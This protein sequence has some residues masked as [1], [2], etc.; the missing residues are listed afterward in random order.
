MAGLV[1]CWGLSLLVLCLLICR[2]S[3]LTKEEL[4]P[5]GQ[6]GGEE[7]D[8]FITNGG[9]SDPFP[10]TVPIV[11]HGKKYSSVIV[12]GKGI[13]TFT[14][15]DLGTPE[16][17]PFPL[18][19]PAIAPFFADIETENDGVVTFRESTKQELLDK[20]NAHVHQA[21]PNQASFLARSVLIATWDDVVGHGNPNYY[22]NTFQVVVANSG[23]DSFA[24]FLYP[25]GAL[26]WAKTVSRTEGKPE[27]FALAG[28][29]GEDGKVQTLEGSGTDY[30][31]NLPT[32]RTPEGLPEG[33][34]AFHIGNPV[35]EAE[36]QSPEEAAHGED[37]NRYDGEEEVTR[38]PIDDRHP[39]AVI[40]AQRANTEQG[41]GQGQGQN[42]QENGTEE[43]QPAPETADREQRPAEVAPSA[44]SAELQ[45]NPTCQDPSQCHADARC[46]QKEGGSCCECG[47]GFYGNGKLCVDKESAQR[48]NGQV[49]GQLNGV[50]FRDAL[51][52]NYIVVN[53]GRV[54][55]AFSPIPNA[56]G[57]A[58][59]TVLPV[60][61]IVGW[62]FATP[63]N[64]LKNGLQ[65]TGGVFNHT[66]TV[67]FT[68]SGQS[69]HVSQRFSGLDEHKMLH[70]VLY[71]SGTVPT[72][73]PGQTIEFADHSIEYRRSA[74]GN[75]QSLSRSTVKVG[76][77]SI[78][79]SLEE[80]ISYQECPHNQDPNLAKPARLHISRVVSLYQQQE[81]A[82]RFGMDG[83][84]TE[85]GTGETDVC[86]A[87][88]CGTHAGC[89]SQDGQAVCVCSAGYETQDPNTKPLVC[90]AAEDSC[91][92]LNNCDIN[93]DCH[94]D[95]QAGRQVCRCREGFTGDGSRCSPSSSQG[96]DCAAQPE[97]CDSN[98]H[99]QRDSQGRAGCVC[100]AGYSGDGR[101]CAPSGNGGGQQLP[102]APPGS[103]Y[104][105]PAQ[106]DRNAACIPSGERGEFA[107]QC[108]EGFE[109]DGL[110][111]RAKPST[112][113]GFIAFT[114]GMSVV[115]LAID[116]SSLDRGGQ[117][118]IL[119]GQTAVGITV[120]CVDA[121]LYWSDIA[122]NTINRCRYDGSQVEA[123]LRNIQS[124]EGLAID[125]VSRNIFWTDSA[126]D[127]IA[128]AKLTDVKAGHKVIINKNL[129]NPRAIAVHPSRG[130]IYWTDWNRSDPKIETAAMDGSDRRTLV[131]RELG[132]PNALAVDFQTDDLCWADAGN[133]KV[134]CVALD[135]SNRRLIHFGA[136]YPFSMTVHENRLYWTD[137][138]AN[139]IMS[140]SKSGGDARPHELPV[141]SSGKV[142][143][144]T[145]VPVQCPRLTNACASGNG[146]CK[147]ICL[148]L[149]TGRQQ[150]VCPDGI[151]ADQC[152]Q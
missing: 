64:G 117:L 11:L 84:L 99:C 111:C 134:E 138:G 130:T 139:N 13:I 137:W 104:H 55:V 15:V 93:A 92:T 126:N 116:R 10:L 20:A 3:S 94:S 16:N 43:R 60:A 86:Q 4:F 102:I 42:Q 53:E 152:T 77:Q 67:R 31:R 109:G 90:T 61:S 32:G 54:Y 57:D 143:G 34:H 7:I 98:A 147:F 131:N 5:Y 87:V 29:V 28:V 82:S 148:P 80:S 51:M 37:E 128:V 133:Q 81:R 2:I 123:V 122:G 18:S 113:G 144:I 78:P 14:S 1:R 25:N 149:P 59:Q 132:L 65:L 146:G 120:D 103:C 110:S 151:G 66:A 124:A 26:V 47:E 21:F 106:C 52:H 49:S 45:G 41:Q 68:E 79:Y 63:E 6:A 145:S 76:E 127:H 97:I 96:G 27:V 150:C 108:L 140:V 17:R 121:Y 83:K 70:S 115:K 95:L 85:L 112:R 107:C 71:L 38:E 72:V 19:F 88:D 74:P 50:D 73:T 91:E 101:S 142:Y 62:M 33:V 69:V 44:A 136:S 36:T 114:Q 24:I 75:I 125:S 39:L 58:L 12:S 100:H 118:A 119:P 141:G 105:N 129:S 30:L 23:D 135:G 46:S 89:V 48:M 9:T 56:V 22:K 40:S 8:Q 35:V